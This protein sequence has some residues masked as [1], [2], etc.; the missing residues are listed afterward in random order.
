M[1]GSPNY[2]CVNIVAQ[3]T[4]SA[5]DWSHFFQFFFGG[6]GLNTDTKK[7]SKYQATNFPKGSFREMR[8]ESNDQERGRQAALISFREAEK[9][10][11]F[12]DFDNR[13]GDHALPG[14]IVSL[15]AGEDVPRED[16]QIF[17]VVF[18]DGNDKAIFDEM[19]VKMP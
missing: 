18:L 2:C 16:G 8:M 19:R 4:T 13:R 3:R 14:G 10:F 7:M 12:D 9:A 15:N 11:A 5:N 17:H 6:I 1:P